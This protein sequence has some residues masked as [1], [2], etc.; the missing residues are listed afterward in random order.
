[1]LNSRFHSFRQAITALDERPWLSLGAYTIITTLALG[2]ALVVTAWTDEVFYVDPGACLALGKGFTSNGWSE[3]GGGAPW[4]LSNPGTSLLIAGWFSLFGFGQYQSHAFFF[5][6]HLAGVTA[7]IYWATKRWSLRSTEKA[8][9]LMLGLFLHSI[10]GTTMYHARPDAFALLLF[11]W[12]LSFSFPAGKGGPSFISPIFFGAVCVFFG[13]QF[14]G[15]FPIAALAVFLWFRR[16]HLFYAGLGQA[17][18]LGIGILALWV[19]YGAAGTWGA[20]FQNRSEHIG[21][22]FGWGKLFISKDFIIL[23]PGLLLILAIQIHRKSVRNS[24]LAFAAVLSLGVMIAVPIMITQI[25][26]YQQ[27]YSWMVAVPV[28]LLMLLAT[29]Q[30]QFFDGGWFKW[31]LILMATASLIWR[32]MNVDS[33]I[34][35]SNKRAEIMASLSKRVGPGDMVLGSVQMYYEIRQ[36]GIAALWTYDH[37]LPPGAVAR[38]RLKWAIV[39]DDD[40]K[41]LSGRL[42]GE[43]Q[44]IQSSEAGSPPAQYGR[45]NLFQRKIAP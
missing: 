7:I 35:E 30:A 1:M 11:A 17:I 42:P 9:L 26:I 15:Y 39:T 14:C 22:K 21:Q 2:T 36:S 29:A 6:A 43:W 23:L 8:C 44:L 41:V 10:S 19:L 16:S 32:G 31:V 12:F 27:A 5:L 33:E 20:F 25:G 45:Y 13:L 3:L 38:D 37:R 34:R 24:Q 18:G 40:L 28:L 4:G